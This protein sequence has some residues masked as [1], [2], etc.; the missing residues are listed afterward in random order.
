VVQVGAVGLGFV[1]SVMFV[2]GVA[3]AAFWVAAIV[4]GRRIEEAKK[5]HQAQTG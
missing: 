5:A 1:V 3:F 2:L 4:L